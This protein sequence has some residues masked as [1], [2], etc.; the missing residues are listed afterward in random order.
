MRFLRTL[1]MVALAGCVVLVVASSAWTQTAA[2]PVG[3]FEG[4]G[5]VG[6]VLHPG[7]VD[8]DAAKH[9]YTISGSG[10]NMWICLLYTSPSPRD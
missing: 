1:M 2:A 6:T 5:D 10:E 8:Y 3:I 7:S 9:T 4:H